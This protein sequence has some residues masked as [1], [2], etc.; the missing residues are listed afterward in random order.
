MR[1]TVSAPSL[2]GYRSPLMGGDFGTAQTVRVMR[3]LVDAAQADAGFVRFATD[4]IRNVP[5]HDEAGELFALFSW[6]QQNIRFTKDPVAKEKLYPPQELLKI[7]AGDCDDIAMLT[8]ALALTLGYPAQLITVSSNPDYPETFSHVYTE[9]ELPPGSGNWV[10]M[11]A[12]R[13][14]S[15]FGLSPMRY[16]RKR[17]WSLTDD[18]Y[19]DLGR[20][21]GYTAVQGGARKNWFGPRGLGDDGIDWSQV[22]TQGLQ[23]TPQIIAAASGQ[24]SRAVLPSGAVVST[25]SPYQSYFTP[26]TP[27]ATVPGAGYG[28][29]EMSS[30]LFSSALPWLGFGLLALALFRGRR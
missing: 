9:V 30:S 18:S 13:P 1:V 11:D 4:L 3:R 28:L 2:T 14:D 19:Q 21:S 6:I 16:Y 20:L 15:Q 22:L 17:A 24:P 12:A 27:G 25:G 29:Q 10:A 7:R 8:A 5:A 26:Y 23:E